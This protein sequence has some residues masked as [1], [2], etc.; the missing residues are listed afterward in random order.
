MGDGQGYEQEAENR[1]ASSPETGV[2]QP[3]R[4]SDGA[5]PRRSLLAIDRACPFAGYRPGRCVIV[6]PGSPG[7]RCFRGPGPGLRRLV[8][9]L[10]PWRLDASRGQ[11]FGLQEFR[12]WAARLLILVGT[13]G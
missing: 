12:L 11:V 6:F 9:G 1:P 7:A 8:P 13:L 5:F 3:S 4:P 2:R 10:R